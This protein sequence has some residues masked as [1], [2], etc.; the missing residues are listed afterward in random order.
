M[1]ILFVG[2]I[3]GRP[4]RLALRERLGRLIDTHCIDLVVANAENADCAVI[5]SEALTTGQ[6]YSGLRVENP[7]ATSI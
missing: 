7:L 1:Q 4:G 2:D 5:Y 3:V 6:F